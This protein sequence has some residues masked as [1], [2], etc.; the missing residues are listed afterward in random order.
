MIQK[1]WAWV[2]PFLPLIIT[3]VVVLCCAAAPVLAEIPGLLSA[4]DTGELDALQQQIADVQAR[5]A[6]AEAAAE[7]PEVTPTE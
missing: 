4:P 2:K 5:Q 7:A 6:E 3:A 1:I